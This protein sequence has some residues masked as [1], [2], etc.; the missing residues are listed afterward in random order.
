MT[1]I[2][3]TKMLPNKGLVIK[4]N[5]LCIIVVLIPCSKMSIRLLAKYERV[6]TLTI[7]NSGNVHGL[8]VKRC[9]TNAKVCHVGKYVKKENRKNGFQNR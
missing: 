1:T 6:T 9:D 2:F 5:L 8:D 7:G 4:K 3:D